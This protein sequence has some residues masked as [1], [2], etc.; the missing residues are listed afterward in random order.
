MAYANAAFSGTGHW[1]M[2]NVSRFGSRDRVYPTRL[3]G[4]LSMLRIWLISGGGE[5][6]REEADDGE[7]LASRSD[8]GRTS[9]SL[10]SLEGD[11]CQE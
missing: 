4:T 6:D 8:D 1:L 3:P 11:V 9:P 7:E 2:I 10:S 5:E